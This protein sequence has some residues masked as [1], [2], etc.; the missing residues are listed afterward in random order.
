MP[1]GNAENKAI[2]YINKTCYDNK[3]RKP[4]EESFDARNVC[5]TVYPSNKAETITDDT[6]DGAP[7]TIVTT[8]I[9]ETIRFLC[10]TVD[11]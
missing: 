7:S 11:F 3:V 9:M 5:K 10:Y 1:V 6:S 8:K 4:S 2:R